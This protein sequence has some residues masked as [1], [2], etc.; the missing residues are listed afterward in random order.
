MTNK[1]LLGVIGVIMTGFLAW[2]GTQI[3]SLGVSLASQGEKVKHIEKAVAKQAVLEDKM[4]DFIVNLWN[5][6][7][8][9]RDKWKRF[10]TEPA[11][12]STGAMESCDWVEFEDFDRLILYKFRRIVTGFVDDENR[13]LYEG[14][15]FVDTLYEHKE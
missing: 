3:V 5:I 13:L 12:D 8:E 6:D 15:L 9:T 11:H 2:G 10:P 7:P 1:Y 4:F 14:I